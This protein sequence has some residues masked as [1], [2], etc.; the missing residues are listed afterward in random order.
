MQSDTIIRAERN[1]PEAGCVTWN[2]VAEVMSRPFPLSVGVVAPV[3]A[4]MLIV[5]LYLFIPE[6]TTGRTLH[7]PELALDRMAPMWP[8]W[9]VIY[10]SHLAFVIFP[11]LIMRQEEQ[12]RRTFMA[13][14]MVWIVAYAVFLLYPTV[15][16]R[17]EAHGTGFFP[18]TLGV[19]YAADARPHNCFPSLHVAHSVVS[20]LTCYRVNRGVGIACGVWCALI[21]I[22]TVLTRQHYVADVI[23]GVLLAWI[24]WLIFLRGYRGEA[25]PELDRR[26]APVLL[27]ALIGIYGI[28]VAGFWIFYMTQVRTF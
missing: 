26:V 28:V 10:G 20:A 18:W 5:P 21:G 17:P 16:L 22:S 24:A 14:L 6:W 11:P 3:V 19:V 7:R 13:Y 9:T 23:S 2:M 12:I 1:A 15:L 4:L 8:S 25:I 27:V